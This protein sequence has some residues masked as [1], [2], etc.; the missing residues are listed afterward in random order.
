MASF[1]ERL[2]ESIKA[3]RDKGD[4]P[5][6]ENE[7][8]EGIE[9]MISGYGVTGLQS[10]NTFYNSAINKQHNNEVKKIHFYREMAQQIE[11]GDVVEDAVNESTQEDMEGN[12]LTIEFKDENLK[13]ND[14]ISKV[15]RDEFNTFFYDT[16]N[17]KD[18]LEDMYT[19]Y[20]I[21]GRLYYERII[22]TKNPKRGI[23]NIR[24]LPTDSMDFNYDIKS[25]TVTN[26]F[27]YM[28]G[29]PSL[30]SGKV[31]KGEEDMIPFE[32][33][34][35][36]YIDYGQYGGNKKIVFGFLEKARVPYNQLKLLETSVII[37]RIV[38]APER[39]VF[40][41]D[42][43]AMPR[44]RAMKFVESVK[45][46]YIKK[47]TYNPTSGRLSNEPNVLSILENFFIPT[48]GD[49]RG[50]EIDTVGGTGT[51]GFTEL[52]DVYYFARK[53]Y[54]A[55]KYPVSRIDAQQERR[56]ADILFG[57]STVG[58][59]TR[60]EVKW[61]KF[62]NRQQNKFC[63]EFRDLFLLHL[64]FKDMIKEFELSKKSFEVKMTPPSHYKEQMDQNILT[65]RYDNYQS[66]SGN[67]EFSKSY[68]MKHYLNWTEDQIT[69]NANGLVRDKELG[70][71]AD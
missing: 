39:L 6:T 5:T 10:F 41:I 7:W 53:L 33:E 32:P 8:G 47:Q 59:V 37:Y 48:S 12:V 70:L 38:R 1:F 44:D 14:N 50:S 55:L 45:Q 62:L 28:K 30:T 51:Q 52:D 63:N 56:S 61:S 2:N 67:E 60:D 43:G 26:Y 3:F 22:D 27:Q 34:Q 46:K 15:L 25:G 57:G 69:D 19:T 58:E 21:D 23:I 31:K 20:Y 64:E 4:K 65:A 49:G 40:K 71:L 17:I 68:L 13:R 35:V 42:T 24:K 9:N 18:K 16:L 11:V 29:A 36:G 54:R 66:F